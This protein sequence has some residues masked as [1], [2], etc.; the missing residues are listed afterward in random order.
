MG[1]KFF[2]KGIRCGMHLHEGEL[3]RYGRECAIKTFTLIVSTLQHL[4]ILHEHVVLSLFL[5]LLG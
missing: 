5:G 1:A 2:P 4:S 3:Q